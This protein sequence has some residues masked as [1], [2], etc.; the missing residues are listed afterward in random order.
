MTRW[1]RRLEKARKLEQEAERVRRGGVA[2]RC[3]AEVRLKVSDSPVR[4]T[5]DGY[6]EHEH[7]FRAEDFPNH[8]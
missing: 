7:R 6:P 1:A 2:I 8:G 4:C 3:D 5:A